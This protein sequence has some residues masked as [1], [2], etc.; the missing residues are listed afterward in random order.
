MMVIFGTIS[1]QYRVL[2]FGR[3]SAIHTNSNWENFEFSVLFRN[4]YF[5]CYEF[6]YWKAEKLHLCKRNTKPFLKS[7]FHQIPYSLSKCESILWRCL[8]FEPIFRPNLLC[9]WIFE[10]FFFWK[11]YLISYPFSDSSYWPHCHNDL[12]V[13]SNVQDK[14]SCI[15]CIFIVT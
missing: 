13:F 9:I 7:V 10:K 1:I 2:L 12:S 15:T 14:T 5:L 6:I 3:I 4:C 11:T 8:C